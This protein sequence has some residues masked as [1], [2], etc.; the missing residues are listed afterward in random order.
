M[1]F[2]EKLRR[3]P[4]TWWVVI[5]A[6]L[7]VLPRIWSF[8]FWDPW[9]LKI[10][11][12]ARDMADGSLADV[13]VGKRYP[14]EPPLD[15]FVSALGMKIFGVGEFGGRIGNALFAIL[16]ILA[17]YWAGLGLFRRRTAL[18]SALAGRSA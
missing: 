14:A 12:H 1:R 16:A 5:F 6:V 9:E 18:L 13:T 11:E 4:T 8:G 15:L 7:L 3:V 2:I 10:G 17:V